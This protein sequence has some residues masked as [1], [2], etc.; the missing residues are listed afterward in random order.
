MFE[1]ADRLLAAHDEGRTLA[2]ATAIAIEGSAPRTVGT[3]MAFDGGAVIGSIAGGC[4]EASVVGVCELVLADGLA[5]TVDFGVT[6]AMAFEVGLSCGGEVRIHVQMM[7]ASIV[8]ALRDSVAGLQSSLTVCAEYTEVTKIPERFIIFGAMEYESAL[9]Q[10]AAALGFSVTVCDPRPLFLT[11]ER[12]PGVERVIEWPPVFLS[13]AAIE[14]TTVIAVMS[15]DDRFDVD[16]IAG[17]LASPA[18]YVGAMGSRITHERRVAELAE[19]SV[20]AAAIARLHSPI[21]LD[22]GASSPAETAISILSEV[23]AA[24]AGASARSL[25]QTTGAIHSR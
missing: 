3:S 7:D 19:R 17:A 4:V 6:D 21:G 8:S 11:E 5:R 12:F 20:D 15:H 18:R 9:A 25:A 1:I 10:A 23:L 22:L 24:R 16:V 13:H 2:V 14:D